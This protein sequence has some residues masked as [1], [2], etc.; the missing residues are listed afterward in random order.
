MPPPPR[1]SSASV[2][3]DWLRENLFV[4]PGVAS[5]M[6]R[7]KIH[8]LYPSRPRL[9]PDIVHS[10]PCH[11]RWLNHLERACGSTSAAN[12]TFSSFLVPLA[13]FGHDRAR[14]VKIR[15]ELLHIYGFLPAYQLFYSFSSST[16][17]RCCRSYQR[18]YVDGRD[19]WYGPELCKAATM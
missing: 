7:A 5:E 9:H 14:R 13:G 19:Y 4:P 18:D 3:F 11:D 2:R 12:H 10:A 16:H 8:H 6:K 1:Q 17:S 15:T